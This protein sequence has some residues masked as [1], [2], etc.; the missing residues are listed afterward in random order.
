MTGTIVL[1][2]ILARTITQQL[3]YLN[4]YKN[5]L[6]NILD[7]IIHFGWTVFQVYLK[8]NYSTF[9]NNVGFLLLLV[10][11]YTHVQHLSNGPSAHPAQCYIQV[12]FLT[13][14]PSQ[15]SP[16]DKRQV[17]EHRH[18]STMNTMSHRYIQLMRL[19]IKR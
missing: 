15:K 18:D 8:L 13:K 11:G 14:S 1:T 12:Y 5:K 16:V 3:G 17:L 6:Q 10:A 2:V 19:G 7:V 4:P 9:P